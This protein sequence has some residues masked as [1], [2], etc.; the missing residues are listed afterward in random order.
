MELLNYDPI[1]NLSLWGGG[2]KIAE[3]NDRAPITNDIGYHPDGS[4]VLG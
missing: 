3:E 1:S 2:E 4:L